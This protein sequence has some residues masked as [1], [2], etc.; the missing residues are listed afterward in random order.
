MGLVPTGIG[1]ATIKLLLLRSMSETL[2][3]FKLATIAMLLAVSMA[4]S[5]G[6]YRKLGLEVSSFP[7]ADGCDDGCTANINH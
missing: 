7:T 5:R 6:L 2:L 3:P 4:T 1:S